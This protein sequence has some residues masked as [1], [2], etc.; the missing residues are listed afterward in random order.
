MEK[1]NSIGIKMDQTLTQDAT[2]TMAY[3]HF[4]AM[5]LEKVQTELSVSYVDHNTLQGG[6]PENANDHMF[7]QTVADKYGIFFS[8]AGNGI[9]HQLHLERFGRPGKTLIGSDSHTPTCGGIG[10]L[11]IGAGG[12]DVTMAMAGETFFLKMPEVVKVTLTGELQPFVSAKD[13]ILE[14]LRRETVKGG[15]GKVY[16]YCGPGIDTLSVPQRATITNMGAELGATTSIFPSDER[17]RTFLR[18]QNREMHYAPFAADE[19]AEYDKEI[20]VNLSEVEP[21]VACPHMPDV[22]KKVSEIAGMK[23]N[24]VAIGSCT[25][26]SYQDLMMVAE[27]FNAS[28]RKIDN[29]VSG[30][31]SPGSKQVIRMMSNNGAHDLLLE[32]GFRFLENACGP[33]IG[34][35]FSPPNEGVSLRTFNRNFLGRSGTKD[36]GIYLVST[37]TAAASAITGKIT[38]PR[39]LNLPDLEIEE[40]SEFLI[41]DSLIIGPSPFPEDVEVYKGPTINY[42]GYRD[43]MEDEIE[44][45]VLFK[46]E[47]NI[48]TDHILPGGSKILPLRSN[49]PAI[50]EYT[51]SVIHDS[52]PALCKEKNGGFLIGGENYGQGSSREHAA[53]APM[54]LGV[55]AVLV[56]SFAR[57][58]QA[59]L[60][61]FGILPL[62]FKN[63]DDY[64]T[65]DETD[66]LKIDVSDL[67]AGSIVK[68]ENKTKGLKY[69]MGHSMDQRSVDI[70]KEGG[71]LAYLKK[72]KNN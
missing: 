62:E 70:V 16:E 36:A 57:I 52:F 22:V 45:S 14:I 27:I 33:C 51:F 47:D 38:D 40:P 17:T 34:M 12:M 69:E 42:V 21:M 66:V 15:V 43:A 29:N 37:E 39:M 7:L 18:A 35:G 32:A 26:S 50:S 60:V 5:G 2:G 61:N 20:V 25:N 54:Y 24:Q 23:I 6:G 28:G 1:G 55:R 67:K 58:H 9:C 8:K 53:I 59:N 4:E 31:I 30:A 49:I 56:K 72:Q 3:L 48:T 63:K 13:V 11:A 41:D 19:G 65:I 71:V 10:M 46:M 68:V 44:S 64:S